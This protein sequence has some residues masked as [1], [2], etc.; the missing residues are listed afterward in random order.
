MLPSSAVK[1]VMVWHYRLRIGMAAMVG[2]DV[3]AISDNE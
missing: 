2:S 1:E 3:L